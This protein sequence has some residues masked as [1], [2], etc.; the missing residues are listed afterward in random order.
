MKGRSYS[1]NFLLFKERLTFMA[2]DS[3]NQDPHSPISIKL[4]EVG[5]FYLIYDGSDN[6]HPGLIVWKNDFLNL[7]VAIKFGSSCNPKCIEFPRCIDNK[8]KKS[9]LYKRPF[10]GKRKNFGS[11]PFD[12]IVL[13]A[14]EF[15]FIYSN[16]DLNNPFESKDIK[17]KDR[18]N[19]KRL[20]KEKLLNQEHLSYPKVLHDNKTIHKPNKGVN[21]IK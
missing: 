11:K 3:P 12:D 9:Y 20:A 13:S 7:Y 1:F 16:I 19:Y 14:V 17:S 6:G 18:R 21:K 5:K 4:I 15:D 10:I 2:N 8:H